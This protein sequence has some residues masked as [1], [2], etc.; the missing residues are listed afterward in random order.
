MAA[1]L[2]YEGRILR[3]VKAQPG[4]WGWP[5]PVRSLQGWEP[6]GAARSAVRAP[7]EGPAWAFRARRP[8]CLTALRGGGAGRAGRRGVPECRAVP[9]GA[10]AV[11]L[12]LLPPAP[13]SGVFSAFPGGWGG[14][15]FC[16]GE[17]FISVANFSYTLTALCPLPLADSLSAQLSSFQAA[18][19]LGLGWIAGV[20]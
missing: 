1:G 17:A 16:V 14:R 4:L 15:L 6:A 19:P 2:W 3:G 10:A 12:L 18:L 11:L 5:S 8:S 20:D 9:A 7:R 13:A